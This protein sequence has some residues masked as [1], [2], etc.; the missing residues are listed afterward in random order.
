MLRLVERWSALSLL[1]L[2]LA[3]SEFAVRG[4]VR[5]L[6]T[7]TGFNDFLSPYIQA[8][9]WVRGLDPYSPQV[10][11][12][13]WPEAAL[14]PQFVPREVANGT[15]VANR[16]I[17]TA[18]PITALVLL[19]P[20]SLIPWTA[21]YLLWLAINLVLFAGMIWALVKLAGFSFTEPRGILPIAAVLA[22]APFH[23][24][25]AT[26]NVSLVAVEVSVIAIFAQRRRHWV[27]AGLLL[28]VGAGLKPQIGLC[29][30]LYGLVRRQWRTAGLALG[31]L[32]GAATLGL[33]R[34][35][36]SGASWL[37]DYLND[38][39]VLLQ[40]GVLGNFTAVNPT[41]LGLINLQV[42]LYPILNSVNVTNDA[43]RAIGLCLLMAWLTIVL[44][45]HRS[46]ELLDLS[47]IAVISL[48]PV[49]H[50]FYDASLLALPLCWAIMTFRKRRRFA[51]L[52]L[53]LM[54]PFLVP[55]GTILQAMADS[56][57]IPA[58][59]ANR[60]WCQSFL[61]AHQVWA[62]LLLGSLLVYE[63]AKLGSSEL[64]VAQ[65]E[66]VARKP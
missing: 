17:P 61:M 62:L 60:W 40:T 56:G 35:Q 11:L 14:H 41:R 16:G 57:R 58:G 42:G 50:R 12:R 36:A 48:L 9:A 53:L 52:S 43:A 18:Y 46:R 23:S 66:N 25:I 29:F 5:A 27:M 6:R 34:L 4:P 33:L 45:S 37:A 13:L 59:L 64:G 54:L 3:G 31:A 55:G 2:L 1:L 26:A 20:F 19:A 10:L 24:G 49:Y 39:H 65:L 7:A 47:A 8:D 38:N 44:R 21:A 51:V 28:A 63:M 30:I 32:F 15:L 22:L